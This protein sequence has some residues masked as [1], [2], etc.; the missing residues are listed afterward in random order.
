V[1]TGPGDT[2]D[3]AYTERLRGQGEA[4][5]KRLLDVQAPYR[6]NLRR[7]QLGFTLD[8][9]CGIGRN[10]SH[11]SGNG[12]G[13]DHNPHSVE[14]ARAR[15]HRAYTVDAFRGSAHA[16]PASFDSL[17]LAHV[18]EHMRL[19]E[20][21][22]LVG[23]YLDLLRPGG[24]VVLIAPQKAGFRSDPSHVEFMDFE[25]L[26]EILAAQQLSLV[27]SYSFP[28]PRAVG[29]VFTH[30]EFVVVGRKSQPPVTTTGV[31]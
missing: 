6:R 11:L 9:G 19:A 22:A 4:W 25:K 23:A 27:R 7:L 10:L 28:F 31:D 2:R 30:N 15:G 14:A 1:A 24:Q 29:L 17:L 3:D 16:I 8:I 21:C 26:H 20:A 5:W 12:V 13:V 18:V